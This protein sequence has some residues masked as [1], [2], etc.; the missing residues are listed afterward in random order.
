MMKGKA[1]VDYK[2]FVKKM[3]EATT[4]METLESLDAPLPPDMKVP[5]DK[6]KQSVE[7]N[8]GVYIDK[9]PQLIQ[10][11]IQEPV[12]DSI[13]NGALDPKTKELVMLAGLIAMKS[14]EGVAKHALA[15]MGQG[16]TEE[17]I[18][19]VVQLI[20]YLNAKTLMTASG[21]SL[22]TAFERAAKAN[23]QS[24]LCSGV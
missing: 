6:W 18:M 13:E 15:A 4:A 17:E 3:K 21:P 23:T 19:D 5:R 24:T 2:E 9:A 16:A 8:L 11:F 12:C 1:I 10:Y 7:Q 14:G 20:L 22:K